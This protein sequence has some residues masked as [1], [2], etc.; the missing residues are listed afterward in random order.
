MRP[1]H[2][3]AYS[4]DQTRPEQSRT[5]WFGILLCGGLGW[6][7]TRRYEQEEEQQEEDEDEYFPLVRSNTFYDN[8]FKT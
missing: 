4:T 7:E 8:L 3:F 2:E 5:E 1:I 6:S